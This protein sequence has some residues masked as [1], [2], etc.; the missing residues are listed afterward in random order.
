[1]LIRTLLFVFGITVT[2]KI[3][4]WSYPI[5]GQGIAAMVSFF[6]IDRP[7]I[8]NVPECINVACFSMRF[9]S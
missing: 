9:F 8:I 2:L 4:F 5:C 3:G 7:T 1:M 6:T